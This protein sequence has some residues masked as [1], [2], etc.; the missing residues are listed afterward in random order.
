MYVRVTATKA[1]PAKL[2]EVI[3]TFRDRV[4]PA[5]EQASGLIGVTLQVDREKGLG[6]ASALWESLVAMNAGEQLAQQLRE[7]TAA[8]TGAEVLDVDRFEIVLF[9]APEQPSIPTY[10][11]V[12]QLYAQPEKLQALI[13]FMKTAAYPRIKEYEGFRSLVAGVNRM[14]GRTFAAIG[15]DSA[16]ARAATEDVGAELRARAAE[17]AAVSEVRVD[18][19]EIVFAKR[20]RVPETV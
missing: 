20:V 4:V 12:A 10:T 5:A 15:F 16:V 1:D 14:T 2:E 6:A 13:D 11:R 19:R 18:Y 8:A 17:I 9:D 3:T 7:E